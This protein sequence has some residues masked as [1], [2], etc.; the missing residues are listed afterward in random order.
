MIFEI[1]FLRDDVRFVYIKGIKKSIGQSGKV[2][3]L[4]A[5]KPF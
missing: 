1:N 2:V 5:K 3:Y 4:S